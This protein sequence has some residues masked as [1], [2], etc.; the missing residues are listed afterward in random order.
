MVSSRA[1]VVGAER[2]I[3]SD[4]GQARA[5]DRNEEYL[6]YQN[7]LGAWPLEPLDDKAF[8]GFRDRIRA[9]M[10]KAAHEAKGHTSWLTP[11]PA[12]DEALDRYVS[13][14]L[15][16]AGNREFLDDFLAFLP[17]VSHHGLINSLAQTVLKILLLECPTPIREPR[18]GI[19]AWLI[20]TT[21]GPW[22][23]STGGCS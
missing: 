12:Y 11:N 18:S 23:T 17:L 21:A 6:F 2:E 20:R 7:L 13:G 10:A 3:P 1:A 5:P 19:S 16:R 4:E 14:V 22:T 15:D 9:Y 8:A